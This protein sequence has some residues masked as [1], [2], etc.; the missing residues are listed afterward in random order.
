MAFA[1]KHDVRFGKWL[2]IVPFQRHEIASKASMRVSY[3][4]GYKVTNE[5]IVVHSIGGDGQ[6]LNSE[7]S[8]VMSS[9]EEEFAQGRAYSHES[10]KREG[11]VRL[12]K[13]RGKLDVGRTVRSGYAYDLDSTDEVLPQDVVRA[14][15]LRE[16]LGDEPLHGIENRHVY[17][18]VKRGFDVVFSITVIIAFSWLYILVA[19][20]VKLD[21]PKGPVFFKQKRVGWSIIGQKSGVDSANALRPA[22][23]A[24]KASFARVNHLRLEVVA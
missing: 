1:A 9:T 5:N 13:R 12:A 11:S 21:D 18:F 22:L 8:N 23:S 4:M 2:V 15:Q 3:S 20:L 7:G 14:E 10:T 6:Q 19:I 17:R 24:L 16:E